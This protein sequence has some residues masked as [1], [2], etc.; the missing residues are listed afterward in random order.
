MTMSQTRY[1]KYKASVEAVM[2]AIKADDD[3][4]VDAAI[5]Q[6]YTAQDE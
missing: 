3:K 4:A 2:S 1:P 5:E 6:L